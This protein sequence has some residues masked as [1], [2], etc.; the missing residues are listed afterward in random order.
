M[1]PA[2]RPDTVAFHSITVS[3]SASIAG[4]ISTLSTLAVLRLKHGSNL[5]GC[6][7]G[8]SPTLSPLR[9]LSTKRAAPCQSVG[10]ST[11][12]DNNEPTSTKYLDGPIKARRCLSSRADIRFHSEKKRFAAKTTIGAAAGSR[13]RRLPSRRLPPCGC[14]PPV[15]HFPSSPTAKTGQT[16]TRT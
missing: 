14:C 16:G 13:S 12:Y 11:P 9:I 15:P 5:V 2:G 3:A 1:S 7:T 6:S 4:G 10:K 8:I